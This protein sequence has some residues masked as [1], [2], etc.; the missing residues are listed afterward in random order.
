[1]G[2]E[3][4][5]MIETVAGLIVLVAVLSVLVSR[6]AQTSSV[7][8]ASGSA[9]GNSLAVAEAPVTGAQTQINLSYPSEGLYDNSPY[10]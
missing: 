4:F 1:M 2:N 9:F 3:F 7:I 6:N 8:Q 5:H 10:L